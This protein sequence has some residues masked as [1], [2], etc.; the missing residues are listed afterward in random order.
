MNEPSIGAIV[1]IIFVTAMATAAIIHLHE[2]FSPQP[3]TPAQVYEDCISKT[4]GSGT[5]NTQLAQ[6]IISAC[7]QVASSTQIQ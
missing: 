2:S 7:L 1:M 5:D 3:Q 6:E 4:S